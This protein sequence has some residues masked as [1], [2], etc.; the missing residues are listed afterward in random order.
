MARPKNR[1]AAELSKLGSGKGGRARAA[2]LSP[3]ARARIAR[4]AAAARWGKPRYEVDRLRELA[5]RRGLKRLYLFGSI[6]RDDDFG[7]DSDVDVMIEYDQVPSIAEL[8]ELREELE[9]IFDRDVDVITRGA[10]EAMPS[11]T[12]R[13]AILSTA[14]LIH[15]R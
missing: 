11:A 1:H 4:R 12:R 13:H 6:L 5:Q 14:K 2:A 9:A 7:S 15:E 3:E 8:I 10:V